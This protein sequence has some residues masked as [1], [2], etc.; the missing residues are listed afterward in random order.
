[1]ESRTAKRRRC[2]EIKDLIVDETHTLVMNAEKMVNDIQ[3]TK[4]DLAQY[5]NSL[6]DK[7]SELISQAMGINEQYG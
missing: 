1:M 6:S 2:N 7:Q 3:T 5:Y 4:D